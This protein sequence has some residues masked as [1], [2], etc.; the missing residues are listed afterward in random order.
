[1]NAAGS[2]ASRRLLRSLAAVAIVGAIVLI[3]RRVPHVNVT[4]VA[5]ILV[6]AVLAIAMQWGRA[7]AIT[8]AIAAAFALD[9]YF[10]P[11]YGFGIEARDHWVA[12]FA[13]L[14]T[15]VAA[16][17]LS[18]RAN[19]QRAEAVRHRTEIEKLYRIADAVSEF[20]SADMI[21]GRLG[22]SLLEI[23]D[24]DEVAV[25]D[26]TTDRIWRSGVPRGYL[27]DASLREVSASGNR[28]VNLE[29]GLAIEPIRDGG[30]PAGS[31]AVAGQRVS[32]LL[33]RAV[34][35][36]A[37]AAMAKA[38][39]SEKAVEAEIVRRSD[40][41]KSAVF[42][43][44]AHEARGRL[45]SIQISA[46]TLQSGKPLDTALRDE[47]LGIIVEETERMNRW[48]DEAARMNRVEASQFTPHPAAQEVTRLVS[49]A[50]ETLDPLL[51]GQRIAVAVPESLP[52]AHCDANMV[53]HVL[54]LLLDNA[55]KYSPPASPIT[56]SAASD[57]DRI[58]ISVLDVGP[59]V[60]EDERT[61]IFEKH[62][63]GVHQDPC[64]PGTGL[65]LA[66]AK[67]MVESQGGEIW[68]TNRPG[69]GAAFHFSLPAAMRVATALRKS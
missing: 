13:F 31:I 48:I 67:Y 9:Y 64:V 46:T 66:S 21:L 3:S 19:S 59:G 32:P 14:L 60:P 63:R 39:A 38:R 33:L 1:M 52:P 12:L 15:A 25:H 34:A 58:L 30:G 6:L 29:S 65:G 50:L 55:L 24:V 47:L 45:G 68:V 22:G 20:E 54:G 27:T 41:L 2:S 28:L 40:E 26:R 61:R 5:L 35:Q 16:G 8:A 7:E 53:Q 56:V 17:H 57:G 37:G 23:L 43:A 49:A 51:A 11:P 62:Y 10:L 69:G 42:D 36:R 4:T 44:L 18:A